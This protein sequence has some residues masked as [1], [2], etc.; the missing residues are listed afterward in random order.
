MEYRKDGILEGW[1]KRSFKKI[2]DRFEKELSLN[3]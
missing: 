1:G 2:S 3:I